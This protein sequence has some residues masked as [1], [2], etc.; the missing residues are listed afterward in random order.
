MADN[1][2]KSVEPSNP[3]KPI[4]RMIMVAAL[5][6]IVIGIVFYRSFAALPFAFGVIITSAVNIL[7]IKMLE[8]VVNKVVSMD[9]QEAGKNIVRLQFIFR[10]LITGAVLV[11]IGFIQVHTSPP[12]IYSSRETHLAIWA[13][14]FPNGPESLLTSPFISLWGALAGLFTMQLSVILVRALKLDLDDADVRVHENDVDTDDGDDDK[15]DYD[16]DEEYDYDDYDDDDYDD[17]DD[18]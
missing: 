16:D 12:A 9:D 4:T 14:L 13:A 5:I 7:K 15:D 11:A 17:E 18:H 2:V 8:N 3:T 1:N 10:F 6:I